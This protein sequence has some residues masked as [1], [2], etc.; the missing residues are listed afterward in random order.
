MGWISNIFTKSTASV[1]EST[2]NAIDKIFTS[3]EERIK[4]KAAFKIGIE[5]LAN[6]AI[7]EVN[8]HVETQEKERTSRLKI[9]MKSDSWLSKNVRPMTLIFMTVTV[10]ILAFTTIFYSGFSDQQA[11]TVKEWIGFFKNVMLTI[12]A[13]YFSARAVEKVQSMRKGKDKV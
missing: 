1:I 11:E 10:S 13:F 6:E 3:D 4:A 7:K 9:D 8:N 12:Y 5:Q 2:G